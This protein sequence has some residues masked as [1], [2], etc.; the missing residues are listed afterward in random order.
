MILGFRENKPKISATQVSFI[1]LNI[2]YLNLI[3]GF[4]D[5]YLVYKIKFSLNSTY[6]AAEVLQPILEEARLSEAFPEEWTDGIIAKI[7]K[8]G[9]LKICDNC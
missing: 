4:G 7:P 2:F 6:M 9:N 1:K 3:Y 5:T 8:M